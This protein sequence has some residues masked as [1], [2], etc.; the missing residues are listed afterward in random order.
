MTKPMKRYAMTLLALCC[1]SGMF[2]QTLAQAKKWFADGEF[3]KA[4]PVFRRLAKQVPSNAGYSFWYGACCYETGE[5]KE[6]LPYLKKS[7]DRKVVDAYLYLSRAYCDL[8][9][10]DEAIENIKN[11]IYWLKQKNRNTSSAEKLMEKYRMGARML[12]GVENVTIV[13]SFVVDKDAFIN[14]YKLSKATGHIGM[15]DD[16]KGTY[17]TNEWE[18]MMVFAQTDQEGE[19]HLFSCVKL[20]NMWD[21]PRPLDGIGTERYD[22]NYPFVDSDGITLYFASEGDESIG[23]YDIFVTRYSSEDGS[24]LKPDN[25]GFPFNSQYNDYMYVIDDL[26]GLGWFASDR[27]QPEGKVCVY[28]FVPN[29]SKVVYDYDSIDSEKLRSLAMLTSISDT[30]NDADK[31]LVA[32]QSLAEA[33]Y[34]NEQKQKNT[35]FK[36]IVNDSH[37]YHLLSDFRSAEAQKLFQ[38]LRQKKKDLAALEKTLSDMR[39]NY[40]ASSDITVRERLSPAILDQEKRVRELCEEIDALVLQVRNTEIK[41]LENL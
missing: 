36:F 39:D 10:F 38:I 19:T 14:A 25:I 1:C 18:D 17:Y 22:Q 2:A 24:Y 7:S 16:E 37:V 3:E 26:N 33:T 5:L 11:H 12:R 20:G 23:G 4:K 9:R 27:Y 29:T 15:T 41:T 13:D 32:K 6:S 28:V 31:L 8:Y 30:H 34:G 21:T 40:A 35:D